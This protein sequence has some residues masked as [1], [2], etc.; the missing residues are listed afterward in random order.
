MKK[1]V[2]IALPALA[3]IASCSKTEVTPAQTDPQQIAFTPLN[4]KLSTKAMIDRTSY[5]TTDPSFGSFA[6]YLASGDWNSAANA[7]NASL[8][9]PTSEVKYSAAATTWTTD[10]PYYWPKSGKVTFFAYSPYSYQETAGGAIDVTKGANNDGLVIY[11]YDVDAHQLTDLMVADITKSKDK[12]ANETNGGYKGVPIVFQHKLSQI[13]GINITTVKTDAT[14]SA[15]KE[16]DYA[17]KHDGTTGKEYVAGDVVFKLKNVS[18]N[19]LNTKGHFSYSNTYDTPVSSWSGQSAPKDAYV[20]YNY[21]SDNANAPEQFTDNTKFGL[22][23]NN[24][25]TANANAYL[26]VLPQPLTERSAAAT[27][28]KPYIHLEYQVL[29]YTDATNY[30]TENVTEDVD[31]YIIHGGTA[32]AATTG[33]EIAQNKKITYNIQINLEN[34]QIY[35]A[36]SVENWEAQSFTYTIE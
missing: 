31:L 28:D 21:V 13:V 26:L 14:T 15:L 11:N 25:H 5:A 32:G 24:N 12:T 30:A 4:G 22:T 18:I 36:P 19:L 2:L 23:F 7:K 27:L 10:T 34:R 16:Y 3:L 33:I 9:V 1:I 17:N 35:W 20:W 29:T 6:Y 8:Y